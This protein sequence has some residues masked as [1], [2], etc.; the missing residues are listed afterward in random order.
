MSCRL[1]ILIASSSLA[2]AAV[3]LR[4]ATIKAW[5]AH[6]EAAELRLDSQE[7]SQ[8]PW[9]DQVPGGRERLRSGQIEAWPADAPAIPHGLIHDWVGA[10]F[11][12]GASIADVISVL[13]GFDRYADYYGPTVRDAKLLSRDGDRLSYRIRYARKAL[14][15][16]AVL[17]I[18]FTSRE[19]WIHEHRWYSVARSASVQEIHDSGEPD[20]RAVPAEEGSGYIWRAFAGSRLREAD[21]GV[22]LEQESIALSRTIPAGL[23]WLVKPFVE[24]LSKE[25]VIS[26]LRR[27]RDAVVAPASATQ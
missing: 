18:E 20:E 26:T 3:P 13:Q 16:M 4:P 11:I 6:V 21:G 1:F 24:R 27:T 14:F 9:I 10:I 8:V 2:M 25:L 5:D 7:A 22:Y 23:R 17:D 12:P 15:V 19:C